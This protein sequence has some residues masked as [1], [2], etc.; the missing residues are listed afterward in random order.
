MTK[1]TARAWIKENFRVLPYRIRVAI[2][3]KKQWYL[4]A[5]WFREMADALDGK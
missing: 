1:R 4:V 2:M 3:K 5:A